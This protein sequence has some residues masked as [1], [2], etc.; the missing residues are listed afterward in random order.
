MLCWGQLGQHPEDFPLDYAFMRWPVSESP[1]SVGDYF[2]GEP[3][4]HAWGVL[5]A[6]IWGTGA[7]CS[8]VAACTPMVG[9]STSF[10]LGAGNTMVSAVW[11]AF[12]WKE[13]RTAASEVK[14][15]LAAMFTLFVLGLL[16]I[17]LAPVF[18]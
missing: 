18:P 5:G 10:S 15:L 8:F 16:S 17:S 13:F 6:F 9:P 4:A 12:V 1:L 2:H 11:G 3:A 14:Y 7:I